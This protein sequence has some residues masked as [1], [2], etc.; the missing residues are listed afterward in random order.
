MLTG[1]L[2]TA[3][4]HCTAL[5]AGGVAMNGIARLPGVSPGQK[6]RVLLHDNSYKKRNTVLG[7]SEQTMLITSTTA[8]NMFKDYKEAKQR[9]S[10]CM[11]VAA[12][13]W[14]F[15]AC[16]SQ[17]SSSRCQRMPSLPAKPNAR[18]SLRP[19]GLRLIEFG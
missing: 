18:A 11:W 6:V 7:L 16:M 3:A 9:E 13:A 10:N 1:C 19:V 2:P 14:W 8:N 4:L 17:T 12:T 15:V 5:I